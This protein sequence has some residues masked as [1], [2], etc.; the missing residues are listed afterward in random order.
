[1]SE[2]EVAST[3]GVRPGTVKSRLSR[4]MARLRV[5]L[6]AMEVAHD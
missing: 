4:A 6:E 1:M 2:R 5:E 3:I